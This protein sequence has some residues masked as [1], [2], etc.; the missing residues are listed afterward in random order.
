MRLTRS[1][2][3]YLLG[4]F[5]LAGLLAFSLNL[6][7]YFLSDDFV[8]IGKVLRGDFSV[9]WGQEHG[10]FFRPL[11]ICS[12]VIDSSI[13]G[14]RPLGFH[15]TNVILHALNSFLLFRLAVRMLEAIMPDPA[16]RRAVAISAAAL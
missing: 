4:L 8:Q 13:W 11:F 9:V 10:G 14:A 3:I 1:P 6:N 7:N 5:L 16:L 15:L 12:Y 2:Q